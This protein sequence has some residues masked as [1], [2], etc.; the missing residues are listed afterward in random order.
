ME[1]YRELYLE[2]LKDIGEI[3]KQIDKI[4]DKSIS[5]YIKITPPREYNYDDKEDKNS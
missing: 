4:R 5:K 3:E 1:D 2:L